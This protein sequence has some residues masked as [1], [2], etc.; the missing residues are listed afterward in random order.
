MSQW[1]SENKK[2]I[3]TTLIISGIVLIT[4]CL[5]YG[6]IS[7][8][9]GGF[10]RDLLNVASPIFIGFILAYLSN[11][12]VMFLEKRLF[13]WVPKFTLKRLICIVLTL[14]LILLF[15][16]F[17]ITMLIPS[18]VT[19]LASFWETYI[20]NYEVSLL[21]LTEQ[22]NAIMDDIPFL[23]ATQRLDGDSVVKWVKSTFP[24]IDDVVAGDISAIFPDSSEN[25]DAPGSSFDLKEFLTSD[26]FMSALGYILSLGTSV[27]NG[28]TDGIIGMF[29]AIYMLMSKEK[30][31]AYFKRLLNALL[32]AP[33]VRSVI[34]F[35][36]LL[37]RSFGGFIEGQVFEAIIIGIMSYV[38]FLIFGMPIPHLLATL[39]AVTNV[40]PIFGPFIGGI[41]AAFLVFLSAPGK[42]ILFIL[43]MIIIQQ[44][45][46]N[47]ICPKVVGD[48]INISS[49]TTM[50][51]VV[52]MGGLFGIFGM[53]IGVPVFAV[54][55][56]LINNYTMNTLRRKGLETSLKYYYI[57]NAERISDSENKTKIYNPVSL[58]KLTGQIKKIFQKAKDKDN[59]K[60]EK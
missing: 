12:I 52:T 32:P 42:T 4:L 16:A 41:P 46:G 58:K 59:N 48:R 5:L 30:C 17:I 25:P 28:I 2:T 19:T 50:I 11:P 7:G 45:E 56:H 9:I 20:V 8:S 35:T 39:I 55:V 27:F 36:K 26:G 31:S 18:V 24:W 43:L 38:T 40:I 29:I 3:H 37:D 6:I 15:L 47:I 44:I 34:R 21:N 23:D 60:E 54:F 53:L 49:L 14:I 57:G 33:N 10:L 13:A 51:A 1:F 22:I